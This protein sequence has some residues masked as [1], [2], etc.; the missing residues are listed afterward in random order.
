MAGQAKTIQKMLTPNLLLAVLLL[1]GASLYLQHSFQYFSHDDE[2]TNAYAAWRV[3]EGEVPYRDF[4]S[5][6][7]PAFLYWGGLIVRVFGR[8]YVALRLATM[9]AMLLAGVLLY[10]L[11]RE[12]YG[13]PVALLSLA[14]FLVAGCEALKL[15]PATQNP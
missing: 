4:L 12:L 7:M 5:D 13:P 6:Q 3:S 14:L 10:A 9:L 11:N 8:S 1:L 15:E 2:Q